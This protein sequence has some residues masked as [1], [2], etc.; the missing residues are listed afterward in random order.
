M[1]LDVTLRPLEA[2][3]S[4]KVR[5]WRNQD[6]VRRWMYSDHI[7][8]P[9]EH[10]RWFA[11]ALVD[12][13]RRYWIINLEGR[14]VGL[15]NLADVSREHRRCAWAYYL[16]DGSVRGRGLGAF[17][18]YWVIEQVFGPEGLTKLCCEVLANNE[19]VWKLH[20]AFGFERE[21]VY[22][23]HIYKDGQPVDVI[24]LALTPQAWAKVRPASRERLAARGFPV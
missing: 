18:E 3:D 13:R 12:P 6:D 9:E 2:A 14:D 11:G 24:A 10:D 5:D 4:V 21:G 1:T 17:V 15:A 7:I 20:E 16:A 22:R 19:P 23:N 8:S